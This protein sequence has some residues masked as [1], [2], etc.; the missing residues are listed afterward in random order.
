MARR[1][2]VYHANC[3]DGQYAAW[4]HRKVSMFGSMTEYIKAAYTDAPL[5]N[6][7]A[8]DSLTLLDF[9]YPREVLDALYAK[10]VEIL[11][12]DHH[13]TAIL[14]LQGAPFPCV[15]DTAMC[16]AR[17]TFLHFAA[18][19]MPAPSPTRNRSR[20]LR[21]SLSAPRCSITTR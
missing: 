6:L 4:I 18:P 1:V 16:G 20:T 8:G 17:L 15:F 2:V 19:V 10:G 7:E 3:W 14:D 5:D 11:V 13:Q 21:L 12:V 9:S